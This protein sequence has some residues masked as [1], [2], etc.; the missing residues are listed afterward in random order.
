MLNYSL[1]K[2]FSSPGYIGCFIDQ[3]PN[4]DLTKLF[5]V[6]NLTPGS[7]RSVCKKK[8]HVYAG[9]QYGYLCH[10]GDGYGKYGEAGE[11]ECNSAC[12]GDEGKKCG[13]FWRN[14]VYTSGMVLTSVVRNIMIIKKLDGK[15]VITHDVSKRIRVL[16]APL[17][18]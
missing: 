6:N 18:C 13:G 15:L 1:K 9:V 7:C 14:S 16:M 3:H 17:P 4:R 11:H 2:S 10:C 12:L 8:G 5:T